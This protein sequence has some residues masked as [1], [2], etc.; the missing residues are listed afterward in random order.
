VFRANDTVEQRRRIG[1]ARWFLVAFGLVLGA[2]L[3]YLQV[4][5]YSSYSVEA[6][7]EH[8]LKYEIPARR[9][10]IYMHDNQGNLDPLALDQDLDLIYA[11]P[12]YVKN[13]S[14]V[15]D[16]LAS[17]LGGNASDY[18]T[19]MSSG[20]DYAVLADKVPLDTAA[21]VK[22]LNLAGIGFTQGTYSYFPQG[23]LAAQVIGFVNDAGEGQYGVEGYL[24]SQLTG[25]PGRLAAKTDTYGIPIAT[26]DNI[27]KQPVDGKSYVLT[28]DPS[29]QAEAEKELA[30]QAQ[31]V[32][33]KTGSVVVMDPSNGNVI[34]MANYPTFDPNNYNQVSDYN[35]FN[36]EVTSGAF[37]PGSG[38]KVFTMAA[39]LDKGVVTENSTY[40]D[41][42]CYLID[43]DKVC[44]AAGDSAGNNKSMTVVL[45]DSL[46]TGAMFVLRMLSGNPNGFTFSGKTAL[47]TYFTKH[48]GFGSKTGIAQANE[49]PGYVVPPSNQPSND[50]T[51]GDQTFGQGMTVTMIQMIS[52]M[53]AIANGG[54]VYKPRLVSQIMN[55]DG[56][57]ENVPV[58][59]AKSHILSS[60]TIQ[61]LDTM[62]QVVVQ[63]GSGWKA[64][65][66]NP[67]YAIAGK[68]GTANIPLLD[69]KGYDPTK[70][71]GSFIG[72]APVDHPKFVMM[73]RLDAPAQKGYAEY[74]TVPLF[75]NIC[76]WLF[77]YYGIPPG[78]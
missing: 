36:N 58:Q 47:Y 28:I 50:I 3:V 30:A 65:A 14:A 4:V 13:K 23:S 51:Y 62:L 26:A 48:F 45:R 24:N 12:R 67:G 74:T 10:E 73:V 52:A 8:T 37:E 42:F 18:V 46:N 54:T 5:R 19:R 41:P 64:A 6:A 33:A 7:N 57:T 66:E 60:N 69:G 53:A 78:S 21:K 35:V 32:G 29:V 49:Q 77:T 75:G 20:I 43:T 40:N 25:T 59:V 1:T 76:K 71:I 2:R 63:H 61:Q 44:D 16:Q 39:G 34:A 27:D 68:T 22:A 72:F 15:A 9:G 17:V 31:A 70:T 38:M 56:T 55:P 11:D